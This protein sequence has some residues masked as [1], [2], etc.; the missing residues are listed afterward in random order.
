MELHIYSKL[1]TAVTSLWKYY[2]KALVRRLVSH[3]LSSSL[4]KLSGE[5]HVIMMY[6][7]DVHCKPYY[8]W[9]AIAIMHVY[10]VMFS[11]LSA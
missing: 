7:G 2:L 6:N 9:I 10:I 11:T 4:Q 3:V 1:G 5:Y 8:D